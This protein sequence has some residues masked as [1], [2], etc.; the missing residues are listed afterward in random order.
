MEIVSRKQAVVNGDK[1]YFTGKQCPA[2]H[3]ALR[4]VSTMGCVECTASKAAVW[5]ADNADH[6]RVYRNE[7]RAEHLDEERARRRKYQ[8]RD[9]ERQRRKRAEDP[10]RFMVYAAKARAKQQDVAFDLSPQDLT[11]PNVCPVLGILL[12]RNNTRQND[13]SPTI[14]R[15]IPRNG[16]VR[17]NVIVVSAKAN[18]IKNNATVEEIQQVADFY[19]TLA[20]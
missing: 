9:T 18:R 2:G 19:R 6:R 12:E 5:R 7:Y 8:P 3:T 16:Y 4:W 20:S 11:I 17:G 14:D 15:I 10:I 13:G 1:T